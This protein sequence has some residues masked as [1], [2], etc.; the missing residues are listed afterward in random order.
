ML[1]T[2]GLRPYAQCF[3][4][5]F[6]F[7]NHMLTA[8]YLL[9]AAVEHRQHFYIRYQ[10]YVE[11]AHYFSSTCDARLFGQYSPFIKQKISIY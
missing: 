2:L 6:C 1:F 7:Y 10:E 3:S 5:S 9:V 11:S 8:G 4:V